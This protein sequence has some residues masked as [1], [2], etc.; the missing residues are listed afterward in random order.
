MELDWRLFSSVHLLCLSPLALDVAPRCVRRSDPAH[1][2]HW[3]Q[4]KRYYLPGCK[5][6]HQYPPGR[7]PE[8]PSVPHGWRHPSYCCG[9]GCSHWPWR[10]WCCCCL[11]YYYSC[12]WSGSQRRACDWPGSDWTTAKTRKNTSKNFTHSKRQNFQ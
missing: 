12:W 3:V 6:S 5:T 2:G 8:Q 11:C 1:S 9:C 4:S 10:P 7:C